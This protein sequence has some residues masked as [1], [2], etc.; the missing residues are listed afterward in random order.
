MW[1]SQ[2]TVLWGSC[3]KALYVPVTLLPH[4]LVYR[5]L[6]DIKLCP[7]L[8]FPNH[9]LSEASLDPQV[10]DSPVGVPSPM[11]G[12]P[13]PIGTSALKDLRGREGWG[14]GC[15]HLVRPGNQEPLRWEAPSF[16]QPSFPTVLQ[17]RAGGT[18][19]D[20]CHHPISPSPPRGDDLIAFPSSPLEKG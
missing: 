13:L 11:L 19:P 5:E 10:P 6:R 1:L 3:C 16:P 18:L 20:A 4:G 8:S 12:R 9:L 17:F 14:W 15:Q 2:V 7:C